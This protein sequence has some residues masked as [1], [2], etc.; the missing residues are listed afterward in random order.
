MIKKTI[1]TKAIAKVL[2]MQGPAEGQLLVAARPAGGEF[3][4]LYKPAE[5]I[6]AIRNNP[7]P[8][9]VWE[10]WELPA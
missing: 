1:D 9:Y 8:W 4:W 3:F 6:Q 2:A 10:R 5:A 7:G